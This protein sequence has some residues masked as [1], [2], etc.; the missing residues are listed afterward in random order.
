M[1]GRVV[2]ALGDLGSLLWHAGK[3]IVRGLW[4]G[5]KS[6]GGWLWDQVTS[7]I[8]DNIP[9]PVKRVL[10]IGSP[11]KVAFALM[12]DVGAGMVGGLDA[13]ERMVA[14]AAGSLGSLV[15]SQPSVMDLAVRSYSE[16]SDGLVRLGGLAG[17]GD[18]GGLGGPTYIVHG[19][20]V[21]Q[22][23]LESLGRDGTANVVRYNGST[24]F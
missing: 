23:E 20:L 12:L 19:S 2:G 18:S 9:G 14:R 8:S 17:H 1:P 16:A 21:T 10:G 24:G 22:R 15:L 11:S 7:F 3:D 6:M 4:N 5:I 13:S